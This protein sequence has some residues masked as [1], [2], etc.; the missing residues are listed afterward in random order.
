MLAKRQFCN[1]WK[2]LSWTTFS[3]IPRLDGDRGSLQSTQIGWKWK[4]ICYWKQVN[5]ILTIH[6]HTYI[7]TEIFYYKWKLKTALLVNYRR[8]SPDFKYINPDSWMPHSTTLSW[9]P[10]YRKYHATYT[11]RKPRK[12]SLDISLCTRWWRRLR[13]IQY[14]NKYSIFSFFHCLSFFLSP[15]DDSVAI[16]VPKYHHCYKANMYMITQR[17]F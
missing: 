17:L 11:N 15:T 7:N 9:Y 16:H 12:L 14:C 6:V 5:S 1:R 10:I 2:L 13:L 4:P 3:F 8:T